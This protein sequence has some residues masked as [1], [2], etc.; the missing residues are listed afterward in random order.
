MQ[1]QG[2]FKIKHKHRIH[3]LNL[4]EFLCVVFLKHLFKLDETRIRTI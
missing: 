3:S 1:H 4:D 2:H